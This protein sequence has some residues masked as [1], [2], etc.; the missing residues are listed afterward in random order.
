MAGDSFYTSRQ[1]HK[2]RAIV[3]KHWKVNNLPCAYCGKPIDW[4]AKPIVDHIKNRKRYPELAYDLSNL[5]LVHHQCNTKKYYYVENNDKPKI[6][7]DG[8]P[9]NSDW[10]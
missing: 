3:R 4:N 5:C 10:S 6:G 7:A 1:W 8:Y 2:T 9:V